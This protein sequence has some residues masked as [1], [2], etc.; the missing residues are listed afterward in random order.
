MIIKP[1]R[2]AERLLLWFLRDDLAEEVSGDLHEKYL[3]TLKNKS[4]FRAQLNYWYQVFHY[5]RPFAIRSLR[6]HIIHYAMIRS[7]IKI[8]WRHLLKSKGYSIIN[9]GGLAT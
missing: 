2:Y 5:I 4:R 6:Y 3:S 9:I 8:G 1:P 7:N